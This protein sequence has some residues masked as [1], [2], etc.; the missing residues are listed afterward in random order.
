MDKKSLSL[1]RHIA[2]HNN[3]SY[4]DLPD[5]KTRLNHLID[6]GYIKSTNDDDVFYGGATPTDVSYSI[7]LKG[8]E[9]LET[10]TKNNVR[11]WIPIII[12]AIALIKSFSPQLVSLWQLLMQLLK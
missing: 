5:N 11:F 9:F 1:L 12:S 6:H 3:I 7:T 10:N 2:R 8:T 4:R